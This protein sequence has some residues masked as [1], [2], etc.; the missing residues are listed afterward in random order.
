MNN[1]NYQNTSMLFHPKE[2]LI[3]KNGT[4]NVNNNN[5]KKSSSSNTSNNV[6]AKVSDYRKVNFIFI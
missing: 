4:K 3:H 1:K 2:E 5:N 6:S